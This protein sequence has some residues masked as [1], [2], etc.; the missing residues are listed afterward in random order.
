M[1]NLCVD[2]GWRSVNKYGEQ[3]CGDRVQIVEPSADSVVSFFSP[4]CPLPCSGGL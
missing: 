3:L 2:L 4:G 1:N